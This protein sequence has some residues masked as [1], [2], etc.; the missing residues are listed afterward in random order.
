MAFIDT[1]HPQQASGATRAMYQQQQAKY[2]YVPNYAKVFCHRPEIMSLWADLQAGIR[3]H[4][5]PRRFELVTFAAAQALGNSYCSLAHGR[6]LTRIL[7][8]QSV[9]DIARDPDA[10]P[11]TEAEKAMMR[12][13][14]KVALDAA[15]ITAADVENLKN[16][17]FN[18]G[19]IFDIAATAAARCFF[20]KLL[21]GLGAEADAVFL[22]MDDALRQSLAHGR[23]INPAPPELV[24]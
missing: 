24:A 19:E 9:Q 11:L 17:G 7:S 8:E 6:S 15:A 22:G 12:F 13:A 4:M 20:A 10:N 21:D 23:A 2:G 1:V 3:R 5:D 16:R 18:D 14:R